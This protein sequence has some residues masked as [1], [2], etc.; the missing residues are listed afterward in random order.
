MK[1]VVPLEER[2]QFPLEP[3]PYVLE[4]VPYVLEPVPYVLEPVPSVADAVRTCAL[5]STAPFGRQGGQAHSGGSALG[6][7]RIT[8]TPPN[9]ALP[10]TRTTGAPAGG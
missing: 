6:G 7:L 5:I 1:H 2:S 10:V 3:V 4:P 9:T 8:A